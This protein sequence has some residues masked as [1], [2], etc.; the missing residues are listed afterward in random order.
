M[1]GHQIGPDLAVTPVMNPYAEWLAF[2]PVI[3]L[4]LAF[5]PIIDVLAVACLA[6]WLREWRHDEQ[7]RIFFTLVTAVALLLAVGGSAQVIR[8]FTGS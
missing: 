7:G 2:T 5:T 8:I 4:W 6:S 3:G 1:P